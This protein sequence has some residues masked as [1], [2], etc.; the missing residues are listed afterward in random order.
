MTL[1][2]LYFLWLLSFVILN[3]CNCKTN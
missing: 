2:K 1:G 3:C